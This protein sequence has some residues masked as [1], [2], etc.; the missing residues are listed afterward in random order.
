M[1]NKKATVNK[2]EHQTVS[3][4]IDL[5]EVKIN[6]KITESMKNSKNKANVEE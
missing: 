1:E 5:L 3:E 2:E 4:V 6:E